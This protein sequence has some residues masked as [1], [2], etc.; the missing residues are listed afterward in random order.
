VAL[1]D[2]VRGARFDVRNL[3]RR[4]CRRDGRAM[5]II[6]V[7]VAL[8]LVAADFLAVRRRPTS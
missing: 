1:Y 4:G 2:M 6:A 3:A 7:A 5:T 8:A